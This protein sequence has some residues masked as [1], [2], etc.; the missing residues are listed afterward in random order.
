MAEVPRI[1]TPIEAAQLRDALL[2]AWPGIIGADVDPHHGAIRLLV[3]QS[4]FESGW[5]RAGSWNYNLENSKHVDGDGHDFYYVACDEY[6]GGKV[7]TLHPP[8]T[9]CRFRAFASL[10]D[11]AAD[12]LRLLKRQY[13]GALAAAEAGDVVGFA[14]ALKAERFY[15][16]DETHYERT[17]RDV[18][19][20][21][22]RRLALAPPPLAPNPQGGALL[23]LAQGVDAGLEGLD[24]LGPDTERDG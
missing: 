22:D 7:V 8:D 2:A 4:A 20:I 11:G 18:L 9:G 17:L 23:V 12:Y 10:A 15:T 5:W 21:V 16:D 3:A 6:L 1:A 13:A 24:S 14:K 19:A